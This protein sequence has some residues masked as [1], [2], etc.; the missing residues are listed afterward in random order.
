M[1]DLMQVLSTTRKELTFFLGFVV[2]PSVVLKVFLRSF[3]LNL[4]S[5][6]IRMLTRAYSIKEAK[7]K[8]V[9]QDM[10]MSMALM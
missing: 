10:K 9:Q 7:T 1:D 2:P 8:R 5:L 3:R 6:A 4:S